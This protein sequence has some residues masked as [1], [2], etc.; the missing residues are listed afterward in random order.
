[1]ELGC[2]CGNVQVVASQSP[3][4]LTAC[5]CSICRRYAAYWAYYSPEQVTVSYR[6][7]PLVY[8][9]KDRSIEFNFCSNCGCITHYHTTETSPEQKVG[10]N[11]RMATVAEIENLQLRHLDG[12]SSWQYLEELLP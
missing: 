5:N 8:S 1:M 6:Q 4:D 11:F 3:V 12:A 10:I 2:H 7:E 9:W